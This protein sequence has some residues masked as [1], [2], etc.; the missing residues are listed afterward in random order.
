MGDVTSYTELESKVHRPEMGNGV[1][2]V[3]SI[4]TRESE[5]MT[6]HAWRGLRLALSA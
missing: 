6:R 1:K 4:Q 5:I 3:F 2:N